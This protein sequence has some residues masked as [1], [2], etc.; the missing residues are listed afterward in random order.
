MNARI[1]VFVICVEAIAYFL[2]YNLHDC[3]FKCLYL[4]SLALNFPLLF[5][6]TCFIRSK[7]Y[8]CQCMM[9]F[10]AAGFAANLIEY[11]VI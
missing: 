5:L 6:Y 1:S 9:V 2:L 4:L 10:T 3:T 11:C 7:H 8:T